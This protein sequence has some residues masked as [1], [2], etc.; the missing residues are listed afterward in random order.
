MVR[1]IRV[2]YGARRASLK[3]RHKVK[4]RLTKVEQEKHHVSSQ[5]SPSQMVTTSIDDRSSPTIPSKMV[6]SS[7]D[8]RSSPTIPS[9]MATSSIDDRSSSTMPSNMNNRE[10]TFKELKK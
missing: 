8:D 4:P 2:V 3:R 6:T 9:K 10:S 7:I 5:L 1:N